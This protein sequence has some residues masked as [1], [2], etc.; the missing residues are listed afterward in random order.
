MLVFNM[1]R[2]FLTVGIKPREKAVLINQTGG[3]HPL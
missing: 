3:P 1:L 2:A